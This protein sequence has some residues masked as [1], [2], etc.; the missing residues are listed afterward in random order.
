M[1]QKEIEQLKAENIR[2]HAETMALQ[3]LLVQFMTSLRVAGIAPQSAIEDA[4]DRST[5]LATIMAMRFGSVAS[6]EHT[7]GTIKI[8]EQLRES[9]EIG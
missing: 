4:F 7:G 8:I 1:S 6:P 3:I 2:L 5:D 9:I